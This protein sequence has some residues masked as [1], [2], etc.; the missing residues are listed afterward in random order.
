MAETLLLF[1]IL[2]A[3]ATATL[4]L[5]RA[6][7][8]IYPP[9]VGL[10]YR[11]G[12]LQRELP[13]GRHTRFDP[14]NRTRVVEVSMV[15]RPINLPEVTV[16]SKD[17][18]AFRLSLSPILTVTDARAYTES[19]ATFDVDPLNRLFAASGIHP[20]VQPS[21]S[22][23]ALDASGSRTLAE[24]LGSPA[25][26]TADIHARIEN[27]VPGAVFVK[28]L[29]TA[30]NL[31]PE[32]RKMFTDVER[33]KMEAQSAVERARG[34]QA[35]L[36]VLS[37]AARLVSDNPALANLRLLQAIEATKGSTTIILGDSVVAP[38]GLATKRTPP[39]AS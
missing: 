39:A 30:V 25:A 37:N 22:A 32:T 10:L 1:A 35:A 26:L 23:A 12:R 15:E 31:P 14:L 21:L 38:A 17:Q 16:L 19:Q 9:M 27:A 8:I 2:V 36:R 13:P 4:W 24:I 18:F 11:D 29:L 3:V 20:A 5:G 28:V 6:V 33:S 7:T 34:E